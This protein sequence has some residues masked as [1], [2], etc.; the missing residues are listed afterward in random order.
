[1]KKA[2]VSVC[3]KDAVE[4]IKKTSDLIL[5]SSGVDGVINKYH[6]GYNYPSG[7]SY[8]H[9]KFPDY[10]LTFGDYWQKGINFPIDKNKII[11]AGYP[12]LE[13]QQKRYKNLRRKNQVVFISQGSIGDKLSK[14]AV[15]LANRIDSKYEIL[16]KLHPGEIK[17]WK[18][19]YPWL[20]DR[21]IKVMADEIPLYKVLAESKV[22]VGV[23]STALFEGIAMGVEQTILLDLPG[24]EYMDKI[25]KEPGVT[26][27]KNY[28]DIF[29]ISTFIANKPSNAIKKEKFFI[30]NATSKTLDFVGNLITQQPS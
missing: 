12:F 1:M 27:L 28:E 8:D 15:K 3:P 17:R 6:A 2:G 21:N 16:Y 24:I 4:Q 30:K 26:K 14:V 22:Q 9:I 18:K 29:K 25:I 19:E 7:I 20:I 13:M 23:N 10:F 11:S 5:Q